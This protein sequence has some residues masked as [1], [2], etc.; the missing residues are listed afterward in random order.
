M[1]LNGELSRWRHDE[2]HGTFHRFQRSLILDMSEERE[3]EGH[4]LS[5]PRF[6]DAD[7][8]PAGHD[9]WNGLRLDRC[10]S[11]IAQSFDHV[12][13]NGLIRQTE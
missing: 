11:F 12:K 5:R 6:G 10:W 7:D 1:D 4:C 13:A 2:R 3:D 8:V 9:G